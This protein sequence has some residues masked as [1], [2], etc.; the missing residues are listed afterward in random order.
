MKISLPKT[1]R[2]TIKWTYQNQALL[3]CNWKP[4][5]SFLLAK[6][7]VSVEFAFK[8]MV[9][10]SPSKK[11]KYRYR[12][13]GFHVEIH[14]ILKKIFPLR[15]LCCHPLKTLCCFCFEGSSSSDSSLANIR[16]LS[17]TKWEEGKK[18]ADVGIDLICLQKLWCRLDILSLID[19]WWVKVC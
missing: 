1:C 4:R 16:L 14:W 7:K 17:R 3:K 15:F 12:S 2:K 18:T 6:W 8:K 11:W 5:V 10:I 9:C 13:W 19:I